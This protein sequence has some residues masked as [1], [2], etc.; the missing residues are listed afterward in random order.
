MNKKEFFTNSIFS[1]LLDI[2]FIYISNFMPFPGFPPKG[3][4]SIPPPPHPPLW[5]PNPPTFAS[6]SW[7]SPTLGHRAFTG[8]RT[9]PPID[10]RQVHSLLHMK[11]E[12]WVPTC[13]LFNW[14]FSPWEL[15]GTD[16]LILLFLQWDYKPF[17][18]LQFFL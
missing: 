9:S 3:P 4:Y 7:H 10:V 18:I 14:W 12:P 11:L 1:L 8:P 2:F 15:G 16:W 5:S 17:Q 6:L 13:V